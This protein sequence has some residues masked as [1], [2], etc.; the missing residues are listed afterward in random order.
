MAAVG[1]R[2]GDKPCIVLA[3]PCSFAMVFKGSFAQWSSIKVGLSMLIAEVF[4]NLIFPVYF[5]HRFFVCSHLNYVF[6]ESHWSLCSRL[7]FYNEV[8]SVYLID[9]DWT[10]LLLCGF[11][12]GGGGIR[13]KSHGICFFMVLG[14]WAVHSMLNSVQMQRLIVPG[15]GFSI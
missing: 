5:I 14:K 13:S 15:A 8:S 10:I 2:R 3:S 4:S 12:S 9:I 7:S 11:Y 6:S 1:Y